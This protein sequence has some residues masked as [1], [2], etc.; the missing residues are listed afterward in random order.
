MTETEL[1]VLEMAESASGKENLDLETEVSALGM[2]SLDHIFFVQELE[3]E[4]ELNI[5]DDDACA[6]KTLKDI[7]RYMDDT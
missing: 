1:R 5:S 2:D 7:A 4:F 3:D 6:W